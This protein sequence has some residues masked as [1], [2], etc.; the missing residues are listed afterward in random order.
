MVSIA[1]TLVAS[2]RLVVGQ[3]VG[4]LLVDEVSCKDHFSEEISRVERRH[5]WIQVLSISV[6]IG[7]V[8]AIGEHRLILCDRSAL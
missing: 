3:H 8:L 7:G 4:V 5:K 1:K 6:K 2:D